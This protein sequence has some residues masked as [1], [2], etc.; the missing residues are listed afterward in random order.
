MKKK[1][2]SYLRNFS[3]STKTFPL[4]CLFL[5][6]NQNVVPSLKAGSDGSVLIN[7]CQH[8]PCLLAGCAAFAALCFATPG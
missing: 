6:E 4:L 2:F 5:H 8:R 1:S 7:D 3:H